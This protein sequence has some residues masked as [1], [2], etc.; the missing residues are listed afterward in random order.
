MLVRPLLLA[1]ATRGR[2]RLH[3]LPA[4]TSTAAAAE[5]GEEALAAPSSASA[6]SSAA[7]ASKEAVAT[8]GGGPRPSWA[9]PRARRP[10][11]PWCIFEAL[12]AAVQSSLRPVQEQ[13]HRGW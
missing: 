7:A 3:V 9:T 11:R 12:P 4:A 13:V 2:L 1:V 8:K 10:H 5:A 6:S